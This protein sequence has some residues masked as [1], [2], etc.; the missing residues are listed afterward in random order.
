MSPLHFVR[1]SLPAACLAWLLASEGSSLAAKLKGE[2]AAQ[3]ALKKGAVDYH[4]KKYGAARE[5]LEKAVNG[6]GDDQC[7]PSTRAAL[8]RDLGTMQFR[9]GDKQGAAKSFDDAIAADPDV[10]FDPDYD[11]PD[12]RAAWSEATQR[13]AD[14]AKKNSAPAETAEPE[15]PAPEPKTPPPPAEHEEEKPEPPPPA[16]SYSRVWIGVAGAID[17]DFLPK[18]QDL[19]KLYSDA[20]PGN[21]SNAYCTNP[22]GT[23]FPS[24]ASSA[25]NN[26]LVQGQSGGSSGGASIGNIRAMFTFDYAATPSWMVGARLG[27][28]FGTYPGTAAVNDGRAFGH[29]VMVEARLTYLFGDAPLT[30]VGFA[31]MVFAAGGLSE[32]DGHVGAVVTPQGGSTQPVEVWYTDTPWFFTLGGGVRYQ[33]SPHAAFTGAARLNLSFPKNGVFANIGPEIGVQYGF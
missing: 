8:L 4:A 26:A 19:C 22:D 18:G 29:P 7:T 9:L 14:A 12:V 15:A 20:Q 3:S 23:D 13:A 28:V 5:V 17:I 30:H 32:F 24:R 33:L 1:R 27:Y 11:K 2:A 21:L 10:M 16:T 6:C 31:P 25:Q